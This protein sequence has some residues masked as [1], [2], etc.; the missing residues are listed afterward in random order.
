MVTKMGFLSFEV[1]STESRH[2]YDMV[3]AMIDADAPS[4]PGYMDGYLPCYQSAVGD[5]DVGGQVVDFHDW[6]F[7]HRMCAWAWAAEP[8]RSREPSARTTSRLSTESAAEP[9]WPEPQK[10]AFCDR[11]PPTVAFSPERVPQ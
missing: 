7:Q 10:M 6:I 8:V 9:N 4:L 5:S 1:A 11:P 2:V 3:M